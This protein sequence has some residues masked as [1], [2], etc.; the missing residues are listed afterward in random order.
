MKR[1]LVVFLAAAALAVASGA[2]AESRLYPYL[3][4]VY[5]TESGLAGR[6]WAELGT[7]YSLGRLAPSVTGSFA[8]QGKPAVG[9]DFRVRVKLGH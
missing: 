4:A 6:T 7:S 8:L 9:L 3:G 5:H 1:A 2:Q